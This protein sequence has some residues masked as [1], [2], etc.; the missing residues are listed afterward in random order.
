[1]EKRITIRFNDRELNEL[2]HYK[3]TFHIEDDSKAL[4]SSIEWVN[5]Y[6]KNVTSLFFPPSYDVILQHKTKTAEVVRKVY[7]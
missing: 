3:K 4:K 6:L 5:N 1:M 7:E 2:E